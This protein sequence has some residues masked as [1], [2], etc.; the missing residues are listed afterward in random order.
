MVASFRPLSGIMFSIVDIKSTVQKL[1]KKF[2]S[3]LGDYVFNHGTI[4]GSLRIMKIKFPSPLGDYVFNLKFNFG[5]HVNRIVSVPSR[6]LCFQS[7]YNVTVTQVGIFGFRPLSGIMFSIG[8]KTRTRNSRP[9]SFPSPLGDYVF[10]HAYNSAI[11][12]IN[13]SVSV[14]SRGLCFQSRVYG[15]RYV[16]GTQRVSVPS[17][18]L[19]FQS[20]IVAGCTVKSFIG[21][22]PLSGI[23][24]SIDCPH[25][26]T[27]R[28]LPRRFPSPLGDYV[29][30]RLCRK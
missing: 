1:S 7:K 22:R 16:K 12:C 13:K 23:M 10:N 24:F 14:P 26:D 9:R 11:L 2:P 19:C 21:F 30:N 25:R 27:Y 4:N 6:G 28:R 3:P 18:G 17:R 29:F 20:G 15:S 5:K 8:W